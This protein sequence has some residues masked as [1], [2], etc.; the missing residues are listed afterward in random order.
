VAQ[1]I[2][3]GGFTDDH[4]GLLQRLNRAQFNFDPEGFRALR[5]MQIDPNLK[6]P[7]DIEEAVKEYVNKN[8]TGLSRAQ[9]G[10]QAQAI[11]L[12]KLMSVETILRYM[13]PEGR[14][15]LDREKEFNRKMKGLIPSPEKQEEAENAFQKWLVWYK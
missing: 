2:A 9:V 14:K 4:Q 1:R 8:F 7:L 13:G 12:D 15:Q 10:P 6:D 5:A 11:G 3:S